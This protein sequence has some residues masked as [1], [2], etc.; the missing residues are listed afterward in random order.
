M[1]VLVIGGTG[2]ISSRIVDSLVKRDDSVTIVNRGKT[3]DRNRTDVTVRIADRKDTKA[4]KEACCAEFY[5]VV[6]DMIC[7]DMEDARQT[8]E[9]FKNRAEQ[10]II[11]S[12]VSVY[13]R[14]YV[15]L[16]VEEDAERL[17]DDPIF[18]YSY[19]K[20]H[21]EQYLLDEYRQNGLPI[22]IVR[23][24][25]TFGEGTRN[26]GTFRQNYTI[27]ERM[28]AGKPLVVFGDGHH[29]WTY[30]FAPD[31]ADAIVSLTG[32]EGAI[33]EAFH[34]TSE[35]HRVWEDL[36]REF[37]KLIGV[38]PKLVYVPA[39]TLFESNPDLCAHL[40]FEKSYAGAFSNEKRHALVGKK[41]PCKYDLASGVKLVY[42][43]WLKDNL[44]ADQEKDRYEDAWV[45]LIEA[46][47]QSVK[48]LI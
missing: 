13:K 48:G 24:S 6:I 42:E 34:V 4:F 7:F 36:Y 41:I 35:E 22:T 33:G 30:S 31:V 8:V 38:E 16:P 17:M 9:L 3:A 12:T 25:L 28:K 1:K 21:M 32:I 40:F 14:P 27:I 29:P 11:C 45:D 18:P 19:N 47:E 15:T 23:P 44:A 37:G 5:D 43:S 26:L 2:V 10:I 39:K 46:F 20:A